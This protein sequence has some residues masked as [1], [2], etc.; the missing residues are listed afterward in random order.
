MDHY[1]DGMVNW[2][3]RGFFNRQSEFLA[4][5]QRKV[6]QR[7]K[8]VYE[9]EKVRIFE[10]E[11]IAA[12]TQYCSVPGVDLDRRVVF[13]FFFVVTDGRV[14]EISHLHGGQCNIVCNYYLWEYPVLISGV[15][16]KEK[17]RI[18]WYFS[19]VLFNFNWNAKRLRR[20]SPLQ[21]FAVD[22]NRPG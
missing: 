6:A 17:V 10:H 16:S 2:V 22:K 18:L 7:H 14:A 9:D 12:S 20:H 4:Q 13:G 1:F 5:L 15:L 8:I 11:D 19:S 21:V 3:F